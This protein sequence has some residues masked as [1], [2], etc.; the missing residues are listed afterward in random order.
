[1]ESVRHIRRI[2]KPHTECV[3]V[4]NP[5]MDERSPKDVLAD[6]IRALK[7]DATYAKFPAKVADGTINRVLSGQNVRLS[8]LEALAK[9]FR[10]QAWELL[11]PSLDPASPPSKKLQELE[12]LRL[13][14]D[15][16]MALTTEQDNGSMVDAG[17]ANSPHGDSKGRGKQ[18]EGR[19]KN[20]S[21]R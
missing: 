4:F 3:F 19:P 14:R 15:K 10:L 6:N 11:I 7:G 5:L 13:W 17:G 21:S 12:E 2:C 20:G 9:G 8:T 16:V 18:Q 1:M